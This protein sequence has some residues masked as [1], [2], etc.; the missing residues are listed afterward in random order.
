[1]RA[2]SI[3]ARAVLATSTIA[4]MALA[5]IAPAHAAPPGITILDVVIAEGDAG[6]TFASFTLTVRRC[7][8]RRHV[9]RLRDGGRDGHGRLRLHGGERH[10]ELQRGKVA[11]INVPDP[12]RH[13]ARGRRDVPGEPLEPGGQ[14]PDDSQAIGT[15]TNDDLPHATIDDPSVSETGGTITFTVSLDQAG[16]FDAVMGYATTGGTATDGSDFTGRPAP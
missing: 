15:I 6:T 9:G 1:M 5:P 11:T 8:D 13:R 3:L 14:G 2:R 12:G 4:L 10:R 16:T 7:P